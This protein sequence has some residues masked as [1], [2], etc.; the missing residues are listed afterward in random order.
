VTAYAFVDVVSGRPVILHVGDEVGV[1]HPGCAYRAEVV[2]ELDAFFCRECAWNG[3][4]SGAWFMK[5]LMA[6][7]NGA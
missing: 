4:I 5:L 1:E 3:R 2:P 6:G 7:E